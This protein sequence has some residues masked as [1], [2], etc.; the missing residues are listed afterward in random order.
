MGQGQDILCS[1][2]AVNF[3]L[4]FGCEPV[5]LERTKLVPRYR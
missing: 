3:V 5:L 1:E 4:G 2:V